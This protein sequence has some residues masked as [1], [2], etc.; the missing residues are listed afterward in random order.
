MNKTVVECARQCT[1]IH[2]DGDVQGA[3]VRPK[4][5][6]LA[7]HYGLSGTVRNSRSGVE[8]VVAGD[9]LATNE[10][11]GALQIHY[12]NAFLS[13]TPAPDSVFPSGF[14]IIDSKTD[15]ICQ[16]VVPTDRVVCQACLKECLTQGDRRYGYGL[17]SCAY[18]GPRYS[19]IHSMPYDRTRTSLSSFAMCAACLSE[20]HDP[21][22]RRFHAQTNCCP[23]C[24]PSIWFEDSDC[25]K[26]NG[27]RCVGLDA[28]EAAAGMLM[29]GRI[30]ALKGLGGYQ[31][32]C[33][34]TSDSATARL[35]KRK[36]RPA[37]PIAVMV[38]SADH[39]RHLA[40]IDSLEQTALESPAGP[41]VI[42]RAKSDHGLSMHIHP[43]LNQV[44]VMLPTTA[45]HAQL[46]AAVARPLAVTSG[47]VE[48]EP[49]EYQ[50]QGAKRLAAL[51]DGFFQHDRP[52]VR[53][54]DDSVVC[55]MAGRQVTLPGRG[56]RVGRGPARR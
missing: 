38:L 25:A 11:F 16:F 31:L 33:D 9:S 37:K 17:N 34:A 13:S 7:T 45:M 46:L 24:G 10:F 12:P 48:G 55:Y 19:I 22:Q 53:P 18:C 49:L 41:I 47:N 54:I 26:S 28:I 8:I 42:L 52:I 39:A 3:G 29:S 50:L 51:A 56:R 14:Q 5:A 1:A 6:N 32:L 40:N 30:V 21:S 27:G 20:Y 23:Q 15:G 2:L 43:E 4:I 36:R 35:R 44:G